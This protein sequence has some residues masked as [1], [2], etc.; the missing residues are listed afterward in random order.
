MPAIRPL[1][2]GR[3]LIAV[4]QRGTSIFDPVLADLS[5]AGGVQPGGA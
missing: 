3:L 1:A 2:D 5:C 4:Q